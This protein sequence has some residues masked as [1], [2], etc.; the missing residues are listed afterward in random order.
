MW[1]KAK[2]PRKPLLGLARVSTVSFQFLVDLEEDC[3]PVRES[4]CYFQKMSLWNHSIDLQRTGKN[5]HP[6]D[7]DLRDD[8]NG[9]FDL[10]YTEKYF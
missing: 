4:E 5:D 3:L 2:D 1:L 7:K 9:L 6:R 10:L 8:I